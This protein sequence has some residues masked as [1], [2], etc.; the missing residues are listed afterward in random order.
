MQRWMALSLL[1]L[2]LAGIMAVLVTRVFDGRNDPLEVTRAYVDG[3]GRRDAAQLEGVLCVA[4][5][6]AGLLFSDYAAQLVSVRVDLVARDAQVAKTRVTGKLLAEQG[7]G[8]V[9]TPFEWE[10]RLR[11]VDGDWC[12]SEMRNPAALAQ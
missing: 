2:V 12:V 1:V 8:A 4:P 9:E 10:F 7:D 11:R 6:G 5:S 3:L